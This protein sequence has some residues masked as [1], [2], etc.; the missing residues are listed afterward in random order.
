LIKEEVPPQR[1]GEKSASSM[2]HPTELE[3]IECRT[4]HHRGLLHQVTL[5]T[6]EKKKELSRGEVEGTWKGENGRERER[7]EKWFWKNNRMLISKFPFLFNADGSYLQLSPRR[8][9]N[10]KLK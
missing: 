10:I 5:T 7:G 3:P 6:T 1:V 2:N 9:L 8:T 4:T